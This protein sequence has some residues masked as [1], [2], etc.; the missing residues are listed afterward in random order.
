V[1]EAESLPVLNALT[2]HDFQDASKKSQKRWERCMSEERDALRENS[3]PN[4]SFYHMATQTAE[5]VDSPLMNMHIKLF[6][7]KLGHL[8]RS[9]FPFK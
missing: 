7:N 1:T 9:Y 8:L 6:P 3:T 2:E 4:V 5:I